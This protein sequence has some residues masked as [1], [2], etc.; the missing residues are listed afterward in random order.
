MGTTMNVKQ[1]RTGYLAVS[2]AIATMLVIGG[3]MSIRAESGPPQLSTNPANH[4]FYPSKGQS[5]EQQRQDQLDA[6]NWATEQTGWDP[7]K[8]VGGV[9]E[10]DDQAKQVEQDTRGKAVGGAARGALLGV[11]IGATWPI[12]SGQPVFLAG[13]AYGER[14]D[15]GRGAG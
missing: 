15:L 8:A 3:T 10:K 4:I 6:Y 2:L 1:K 11:A 7:Y 12:S 13:G 9:V 5:A 14:L